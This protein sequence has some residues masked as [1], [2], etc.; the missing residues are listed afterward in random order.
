MKPELRPEALIFWRARGFFRANESLVKES[1]ELIT[2]KGGNWDR[3]AD[4]E[5][6]H[7]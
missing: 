7:I 4:G 6:A 3:F 1:G 2:S 5:I